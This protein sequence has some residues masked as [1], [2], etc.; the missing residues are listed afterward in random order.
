VA[1]K[2]A[3][4]VIEAYLENF[5]AGEQVLQYFLGGNI[6]LFG[7]LYRFNG[8]ITKFKAELVRNCK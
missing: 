4:L 6:F 1:F 2:E 3:L 7:L 8:K 5:G